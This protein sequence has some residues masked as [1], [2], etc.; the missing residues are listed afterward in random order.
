MRMTISE[1]K[2]AV[3]AT[4][5]I[6]AHAAREVT[7]V[8]VD[9][10]KVVPG[11]LFVC[12][13][14]T[15]VDGHDFAAKAVDAGAV[16]VLAARELPEVATRAAVLVVPDVLKALGRLARYWRVRAG[17]SVAAISGSVGKTTVKEFVAS[18]VGQ[19][20]PV[21]K[22]PGNFN[23][24]LGLPLSVLSASE[25][26]RIWI[27]EVGVSK[28]GDMDELADICMPDVALVHNVGPAH[29]EGLGDVAGV[30]RAKARLFGSLRRSGWGL[31][32][33]DYPELWDAAGET[34]PDVRGLSTK[35]RAVPYYATYVGPDDKGG[36]RFRLI[37]EGDVFEARLPFRGPHMLENVLASAAMSRILGASD[38]QIVS[39]LANASLPVQ[40]YTC[41]VC[42]GWT[43]IDDTYNA[44]PLSMTRAIESARA[45]SLGAPLVL[46]LGEMGEL[47]AY[48]ALAHEELGRTVAGSGAVAVF[49]K[50]AQAGRLEKGLGQ[51][52]FSGTFARIATPEAF[53]SEFERLGLSGGT[54]LF[55]GSRSQ[56]MEQFAHAFMAAQAGNVQ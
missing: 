47:G 52:G 39:G 1:I 53:L 48:S 24:Q 5:N 33:M 3:Q 30:A 6:R 55:K 45:Q 38:K 44:N 16:A 12:L 36:E 40:R 27:F 28:P 21:M 2:A 20:G 8:S 23:N 37:L 25:D 46:V 34:F 9:S 54:I 13:P 56:G 50:G 41:R 31:A 19:I 17:G 51:A 14:G 7:S 35:V 4:G 43:V 29:L 11:G 18:I 10:R 42:G 49:Y 32:N 15:R 26:Q 22:N